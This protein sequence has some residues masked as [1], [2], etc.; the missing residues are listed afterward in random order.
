MATETCRFCFSIFFFFAFLRLKRAAVTLLNMFIRI[1]SI[2]LQ[3]QM[4]NIPSEY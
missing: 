3:L 4:A 2:Q 1:F